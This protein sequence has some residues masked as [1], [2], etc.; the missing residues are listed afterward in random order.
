MFFKL[1]CTYSRT[2]WS[3]ADKTSHLV[4]VI[5]PIKSDTKTWAIWTRT[6]LHTGIDYTI[7]GYIS[8]SPNKKFQDANG[9]VAYQA[10]YNA[11]N[12]TSLTSDLI[13]NFGPEPSFDENESIPF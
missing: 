1:N 8:E 11:T 12:I 6:E 5:E 13:N 4:Q 7:E 3:N 2:L 9:K 10:N